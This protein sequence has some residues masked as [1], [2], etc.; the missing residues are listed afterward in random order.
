MQGS[1]VYILEVIKLF[2]SWLW[3]RLKVPIKDPLRRS[4][5]CYLM[6]LTNYLCLYCS[7][8][9]WWDLINWSWPM[10]MF[11]LN[12]LIVDLI[13]IL[14]PTWSLYFGL[15]MFELLRK[16][17]FPV[18]YTCAFHSRIFYSVLYIN[19]HEFCKISECVWFVKETLLYNSRTVM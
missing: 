16:P 2:V 8:F 19:H 6:T 12:I 11:V 7:Y 4:P 15:G 1:S 14:S 10:V 17:V 13:I 3:K 9:F 5:C 18:C